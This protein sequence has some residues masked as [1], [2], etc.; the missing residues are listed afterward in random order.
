MHKRR[1]VDTGSGA[2]FGAFLNHTP[3]Q[4]D[5]QRIYLQKLLDMKTVQFR[6]T[7]TAQWSKKSAK[8]KRLLKK[9]S[10]LTPSD[11]NVMED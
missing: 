9:D 10:P 6:L 5:D 1:D 8:V 7:L 3:P 11:E 2:D 4:E